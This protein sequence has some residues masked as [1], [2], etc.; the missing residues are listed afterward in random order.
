MGKE[1]AI[2]KMDQSIMDKLKNDR[3]RGGYKNN[4]K[5]G[6]GTL[7]ESDGT[8]KEGMYIDGKPDGEHNVYNKDG[9][10]NM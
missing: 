3:Y 8:K 4:K 5:E 10:Y 2:I 7:V 9:K 1:F 6:F